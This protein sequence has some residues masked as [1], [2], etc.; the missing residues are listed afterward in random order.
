MLVNISAGHIVA[1]ILATGALVCVIIATFGDLYIDNR[2]TPNS[3]TFHTTSVRVCPKLLQCRYYYYEDLDCGK[4][5]WLDKDSECKQLKAAGFGSLILF[6]L[7]ALLLLLSILTLFNQRRTFAR[8][9]SST[10]V[11]VYL[12]ALLMWCAVFPYQSN[13]ISINQPGYGLILAAIGFVV[14]CFSAVLACTGKSQTYE[15]A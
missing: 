12:L 10:A 6:C 1:G 11:L 15:R 14:A 9:F 2:N 8:L 5:E 13:E 7:T 4:L 3:L